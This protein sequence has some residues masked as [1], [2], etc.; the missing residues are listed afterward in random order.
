MG[1]ESYD[2]ASMDLVTIKDH[3]ASHGSRKHKS[4]F[5]VLTQGVWMA[6]AAVHDDTG[7]LLALTL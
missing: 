3:S 4:L 6:L 1:N 5:H 2:A 7:K